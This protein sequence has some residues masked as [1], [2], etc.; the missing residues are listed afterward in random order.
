MLI[1]LWIIFFFHFSLDNSFSSQ[2]VLVTSI[3]EKIKSSSSVSIAETRQSL[4]TNFYWTLIGFPQ[5][6]LNRSSEKAGCTDSTP[7]FNLFANEV[8]KM[9]FKPA[10]I[11]IHTYFSKVKQSNFIRLIQKYVNIQ[12]VIMTIKILVPVKLNNFPFLELS[13][14]I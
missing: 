13:S 5:H 6:S 2:G 10:R 11:W 9:C 4:K 7:C 1:L 8:G 3:N 12:F 14:Y